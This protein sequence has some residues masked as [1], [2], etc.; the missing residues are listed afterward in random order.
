MAVPRD[1]GV[2][3]RATEQRGGD[4]VRIT[5]RVRELEGSRAEVVRH[6]RV[7]VVT[8]PDG[9]SREHSRRAPG[10]PR[11]RTARGRRAARGPA[12]DP[13]RTTPKAMRPS[14][15]GARRRGVLPAEVRALAYGVEQACA[16]RRRA[17]SARVPLAP[18]RRRER[19]AARRARPASCSRPASGR[20]RCSAAS[21]Q[22]AAV[23]E[24]QC[25][26]ASS[27]AARQASSTSVARHER[28]RRDQVLRAPARADRRPSHRRAASATRACIRWRRNAGIDARISSR[29]SPWRSRSR[30][31]PAPS[32]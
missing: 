13:R 12:R 4:R 10:D 20:R 8:A 15:A 25:A 6:R 17:R 19:P 11:R 26:A 30:P 1:A 9:E 23:S 16:R 31:C 3:Q 29:S 18:A 24:F 22:R 5:E 21:H 7:G 14:R 27:A 28:Q 32:R 2:R